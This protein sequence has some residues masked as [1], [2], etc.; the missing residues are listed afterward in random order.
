MM[1]YEINATVS[2]ELIEKYED[3]MKIRHI[4][5]LMR[6]GYFLSAEMSRAEEGRY[7][8]RYELRDQETLEQY[9]GNDAGRL[10]EDFMRHFPDGVNVSREIW[11]V[12]YQ[13]DTSL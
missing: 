6:T 3:Y 9:L 8:I 5:D 11:E 13:T 10:R 7:R 2:L 1:I 12:L 4:P